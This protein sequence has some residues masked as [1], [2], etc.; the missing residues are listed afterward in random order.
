MVGTNPISL[1]VSKQNWASSEAD[2]MTFIRAKSLANKGF[3]A[4]GVLNIPF[5]YYTFVNPF[6]PLR[7][8]IL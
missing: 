8:R 2:W 4:F 3:L 5:F 1:F 7:H 6:H